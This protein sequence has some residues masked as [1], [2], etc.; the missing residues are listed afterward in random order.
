MTNEQKQQIVEEYK[1]HLPESIIEK[2]EII[3]EWL[4]QGILDKK[5]IYLIVSL[6]Y[7]KGQSKGLRMALGMEE[8]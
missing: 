4:D 3:S 5:D 7:T 2:V 1:T 8:S 6:A